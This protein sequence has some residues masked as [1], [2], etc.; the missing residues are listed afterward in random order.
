MKNRVLRGRPRPLGESVS[1]KV[2]GV[3][4]IKIP[5][6]SFDPLNTVQ[7]TLG[8]QPDHVIHRL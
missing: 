6:P 3:V 1:V 5:T 2:D 8:D 4:N 7:R